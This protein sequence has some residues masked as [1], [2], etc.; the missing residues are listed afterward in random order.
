MCI[1]F[2]AA[3][4]KPYAF[5]FAIIRSCGRQSKAFERSVRR[6]PNVLPLS[7][8]FFYVL[9]DIIKWLHNKIHLNLNNVF[10]LML[11]LSM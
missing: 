1:N 10:V 3:K 9:V 4:L 8:H 7:T 2:D 5:N 11:L 6:T